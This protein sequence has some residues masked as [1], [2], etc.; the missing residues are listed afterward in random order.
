MVGVILNMVGDVLRRLQR[1][2]LKVLCVFHCYCMEHSLQYYLIGGALLGSVRYGGFIPWDDDIDVGMF[3]EDYDRLQE[4]WS[5]HPIRG[6]F[7]YSSTTDPEFSRGILKLRVDGTRLEEFAVPDTLVHNG[8]YIDIFPIDYADTDRGLAMALRGGCIRRLLSLRSIRSGY[9]NG[10]LVVLKRII[11]NLLPLSKRLIDRALDRLCRAGDNG[12]RRYA[13]LW[14]HNYHW[15]R[16]IHLSE[17]FG[18]GSLCA[19]EGRQFIGPSDKDRFLSKV[20]GPDYLREPPVQ[21]RRPP[22]SYTR[23]ELGDFGDG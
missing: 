21:D 12:S 11:K 13:V 22:H 19:F 17:V 4:L 6:Y 5:E 23:I 14:V 7:L 10:R 16:Q 1:A 20:F 18:L 2:E 9:D 3:R 8:V 15:R